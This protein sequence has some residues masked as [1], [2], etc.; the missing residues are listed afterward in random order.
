MKNAIM[1]TML[2]ELQSEVREVEVVQGESK[3]RAGELCM[4]GACIDLIQQKIN[5]LEDEEQAESEAR[6]NEITS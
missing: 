3:I 5:V 1:V 4:K 2:K 6:K